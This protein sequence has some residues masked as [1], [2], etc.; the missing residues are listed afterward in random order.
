MKRLRPRPRPCGSHFQAQL[1]YHRKSC[2]RR[3]VSFRRRPYGS[4]SKSSRHSAG[5]RQGSHPRS[6][7]RIAKLPKQL[8]RTWRFAHSSKTLENAS[9]SRVVIERPAQTL[10]SLSTPPGPVSLSARRVRM[11]M[12]CADTG[13]EN[14]CPGAY[15][16]RGDS[17]AG[18]R[19]QAG[20]AKRRAAAGAPRDVPPRHE[21]GGAERHAPGRGR[22]QSRSAAGWAVQKLPVP[23]GI[24]RVGS[25]ARCAR[26]S[27][28]RRTR[29]PPPTVSWV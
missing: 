2:R 25:A 4:E 26:T 13:R 11:L 14:G 3:S 27:I 24:A 28:T 29:R 9:V 17:Q 7:M 12:A 15:Q 8:I 5:Y 19:R 16:H 21:A 23:N 18:S 1:S 10:V 20:S 22:R 6:G